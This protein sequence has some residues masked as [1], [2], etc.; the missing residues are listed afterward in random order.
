MLDVMLYHLLP[1]PQM[2]VSFHILY[3]SKRTTPH[4]VCNIYMLPLSIFI[5]SKSNSVKRPSGA[6]VY[7]FSDFL[8]TE[9]HEPEVIPRLSIP[10]CNNTKQHKHPFGVL[11]LSMGTRLVWLWSGFFFRKRFLRRPAQR[12]IK[13]VRKNF[14]GDSRHNVQLRNSLGWVVFPTARFANVLFHKSIL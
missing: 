4:V 11:C 2:S 9:R 14:K 8:I 12:T 6:N 1:P 10:F 7:R 13:R 5:S 3:E